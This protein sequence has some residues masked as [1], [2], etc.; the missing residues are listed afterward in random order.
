MN[1]MPPSPIGAVAH[2]TPAVWAK[3]NRQMI[4]KAIG[5]FAHEL[6]LE[7]RQTRT[8]GPWSHYVLDTEVPEIEYRFRARRYALDHWGIDARSLCKL[9]RGHDAPLDAA[10][11]DDL[12][13]LI[14]SGWKS[15]ATPGRYSAARK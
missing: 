14:S 11:V 12:T 13:N 6:L 10:W 15:D 5:E 7:P 2:L 9:E 8:E 3:V 4:V 1:S